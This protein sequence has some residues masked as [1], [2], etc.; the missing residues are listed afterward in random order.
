MPGAHAGGQGHGWLAETIRCRSP[1]PSM[2]GGGQHPD[3]PA[4]PRH[5]FHPG[6]YPAEAIECGRGRR[7]HEFH[8]W[9]DFTGQPELADCRNGRP[10]TRTAVQPAFPGRA[11]PTTGKT[12]AKCTTRSSPA[13]RRVRRKCTTTKFRAVSI[14]TCTASGCIGPGNLKE[15]YAI[16]NRSVRRH[17]GD[18]LPKSWATWRS[19]GATPTA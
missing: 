1:D 19:T 9:P 14:P 5:R 6:R 15:N 16:V 2:K 11:T 18:R 3:S 4:H 7:L 17:H 12:C 8:V 13:S 10:A